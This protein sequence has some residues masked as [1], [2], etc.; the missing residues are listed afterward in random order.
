MDRL[1]EAYHRSS[2]ERRESRAGISIETEIVADMLLGSEASVYLFISL[3]LNFYL[4]LKPIHHNKLK[5]IVNWTAHTVKATNE[6]AFTDF[7]LVAIFMNEV[8]SLQTHRVF[9][10]PR[11]VCSFFLKAARLQASPTGSVS[12]EGAFTI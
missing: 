3:N 4:N 7:R 8:Q 12:G 2:I 6:Q 10:R 5:T 1:T 9:V 11:S